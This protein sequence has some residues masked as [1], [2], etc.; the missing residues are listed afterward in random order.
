MKKKIFLL[1]FLIIIIPVTL[2]YAQN[3]ISLNFSAGA[4]S[5]SGGFSDLYKAG[6]S[7]EGVLLYAT[8]IPGL[9]VSFS[10]G[11]NSFSYKPDY[12]IDQLKK[13]LTNVTAVTGFYIDW[14]AT[15]IPVMAGARFTFPDV[16]FMPYVSGEIGLHY[17]TF[18]ERFNGSRV[19]C[20]SNDP[21]KLD[22]TNK[23]YESGS[24]T[25]F[26]FSL[27][28]GI[29]LSVASSVYLDFGIKYNFAS[30][31]YSKKFDVVR[32]NN[33]SFTS[34]ELKNASFITARIGFV[35]DL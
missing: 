5:P 31:T 9:D 17:M 30:V 7:V 6:G 27:G 33:E 23:A 14:S 20:S 8:S 24:E 28:G 10:L 29:V 1:S 3:P 32:Y 35:I 25:G 26:G 34:P 16:G 19:L 13:N 4:N 11:Y 2:L 15:D 21:L 12:F 18:N 22:S